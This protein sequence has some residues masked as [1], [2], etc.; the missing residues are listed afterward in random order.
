MLE[1]MD[2][3]GKTITADAMHCQNA[4]CEKIIANGG[5]YAF[6]LKGN[7]GSLNDYTFSTKLLLQRSKFTLYNRLLIHQDCDGERTSL[8]N[9]KSPPYE[10]GS[11]ANLR[12]QI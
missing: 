7:Q 3:K 8:R 12:K 6:G 4:A 10:A 1:S 11:V 9:R 5:D 2:I